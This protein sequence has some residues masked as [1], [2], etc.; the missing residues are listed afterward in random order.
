ME[1][2]PCPAVVDVYASWPTQSSDRD[3]SRGTADK[4]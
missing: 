4:V 1:A 3:W 2:C